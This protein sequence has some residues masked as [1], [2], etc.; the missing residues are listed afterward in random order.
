[1]KG[2]LNARH[3]TESIVL[4]RDELQ[5]R[6]RPDPE[7]KKISSPLPIPSLIYFWMR[8]PV[9]TR[10]I[11]FMNSNGS[12][13]KIL[14]VDILIF[15]HGQFRAPGIPIKSWSNF[16][17]EFWARLVKISIPTRDAG[18]LSRD[19]DLVSEHW[20]RVFAKNIRSNEHVMTNK[21]CRTN[22]KTRRRGNF[23]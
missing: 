12:L 17:L 11:F 2:A 20:P 21:F 4:K 7:S 15:R 18:F 1:M 8:D 23:L 14:M 13:K 9:P 22:E 6:S 3:L 5:S 16:W 10:G 19:F